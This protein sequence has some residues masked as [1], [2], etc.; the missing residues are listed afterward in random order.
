MFKIYNSIELG[1]TIRK[2]RI[3]KKLSQK[4]LANK[5]DVPQSSIS[6]FENGKGNFNIIKL[7]L[8]AETLN[9]NLDELLHQ[10]LNKYNNNNE[11]NSSFYY[12]KLKEFIFNL[13]ESKLISIDNFID[14]Y[15]ECKSKLIKK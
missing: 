8:I 15:L 1:Q 5:I 6:D 7:S 13:D 10:Y 11:N 12:M 14:Y 3:N 4:E 9:T 2:L